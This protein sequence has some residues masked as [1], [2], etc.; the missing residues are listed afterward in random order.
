[1]FAPKVAKTQT[2][3]AENLTSKL[4]AKRSAF[5][6][7]RLGHD[8]VESA[9][10]RHRTIGNQ[11]ML[12]LLPQPASKPSGNQRDDT[13][14]QESK[15]MHEGSAFPGRSWS[16]SKVSL[17]PPDPANAPQTSSQLA[18]LRLPGVIQPKLAVGRVNDPLEYEADRVADQVVR[19]PDPKLPIAARSSQISL[20]CASCEDGEAKIL[21]TK[22]ATPSKAADEPVTRLTGPSGSI[23]A[24]PLQVSR[25]CAACEKG[26]AGTQ[27]QTRR[28]G[29]ADGAYCEAGPLVED[30]LSSPGQPLEPK[31][32]S[33]YE[34]RLGFDFSGVRIHLGPRAAASAR[35]MHAYAYTVGSD[36]VFDSGRYAPEMQEGQRLLVHELAHVVQQGGAL[37]KPQVAVGA[38][39]RPMPTVAPQPGIARFV[40]RF[41]STEPAGGCGLCYGTP[42]NAGKAA[43]A[44]IQ[45]EFQ[46]LYPTG[47]VELGLVSSSDDNGRLDLAIAVPGGFQIGEI[48]PANEQGYADGILQ[49]GNY[50]G[51][52]E[53]RYPGAS[54]APLMKIL[55]PTIFPTLSSNCPTQG[56]IVNPPVGGVYGYYCRPSYSELL[57]RSCQCPPPR[58]TQPQE[59]EAPEKERKKQPGQPQTVPAPQM[60]Q[61]VTERILQFV[62]QLLES[63]AD[64][65]KSV[66]KFLQENPD[67]LENIVAIVAGIAAA[68]IAI[69][70]LS[71]GSA[72]AKDPVVVAV[73]STMLRIARVLRAAAPVLAAP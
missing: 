13:P 72:I 57:R 34:S 26:E 47:L 20:K 69:D 12:R 52:I 56:L 30:V 45:Q 60:P 3:A 28:I 7:D 29:A 71:G 9:L 40:Q 39:A 10:L 15:R 63:G 62:K 4:A 23:A 25:K 65:E 35:T 59:Q 46:V 66:T 41:L 73:L 11:G 21:Q 2:K 67:I 49:I 36:I 50:I 68:D 5:R 58:L 42:A 27:V 18:Q 54:V 31:I 16:F 37:A 14:G 61:P 1:M 43:H 8:L 53:A 48:K 22:S 44:L 55:P 51:Q 33:W 19:M 38:N 24:S 32:R 70:I 6:E 64:I 17:F